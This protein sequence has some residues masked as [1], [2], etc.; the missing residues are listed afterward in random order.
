MIS[1]GLCDTEQWSND[2]E[3]SSYS[4]FDQ[5]NVAV[6]ILQIIKLSKYTMFLKIPYYNL[7]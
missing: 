2:A 5:I 4:I 6:Q 3:D 1:E 7:M